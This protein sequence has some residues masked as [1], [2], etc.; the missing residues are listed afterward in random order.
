MNIKYVT[1]AKKVD[2]KLVKHCL[3]SEFTSQYASL[4]AERKSFDAFKAAANENADDDDDDDEEKMATSGRA[5]RRKMRELGVS[6]T[7]QE[8]ADVGEAIG[9]DFRDLLGAVPSRLPGKDRGELSVPIAF[10]CLLH[11]CNE[12]T[13]KLHNPEPLESLFISMQNQNVV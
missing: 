12:K 7:E 13:L 8:D 11:L 9:V 6:S 10:I 2:V 5:A 3:W 4:P 1:R